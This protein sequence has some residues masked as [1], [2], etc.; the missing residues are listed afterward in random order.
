MFSLLGSLLGF[1]T[2]VLAKDDGLF[3]G[4]AGQEA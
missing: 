4:Q 2:S 3:S 1:G